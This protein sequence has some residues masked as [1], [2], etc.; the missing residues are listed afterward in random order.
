MAVSGIQGNFAGGQPSQLEFD[1]HHEAAHAVMGRVWA[2]EIHGIYPQQGSGGHTAW[3]TSYNLG[4]TLRPVKEF[5]VPFRA[6]GLPEPTGIPDRLTTCLYY[7]AGKTAE[8]LLAE[9]AGTSLLEKWDGFDAEETLKIM[10]AAIAEEV[11]EARMS[12]LEDLTR[13]I[14]S[15]PL[16]WY[17]VK[18]LAQV[19]T[20]KH[21]I[22]GDRVHAIISPAIASWTAANGNP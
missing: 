16:C 12:E 13:K 6:W 1:A 18:E 19:L 20:Q 15:H 5:H 14:L 10:Q 9:E 7:R 17:V 8:E 3:V 22:Q 4:G 11:M 2:W 21:T